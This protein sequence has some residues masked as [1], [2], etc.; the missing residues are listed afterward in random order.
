MEIRN[1]K[2]QMD[3][4]IIEITKCVKQ[5]Q[6]ILVTTLTKRMAEDL[7][8]YLSKKKFVSVIYIQKFKVFKELN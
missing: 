4:L 5:D 6:R 2:G 7:A 1:S 3:D 8:E